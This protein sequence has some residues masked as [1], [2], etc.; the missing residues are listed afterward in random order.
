LPA[1]DL[2]NTLCATGDYHINNK[3]SLGDFLAYMDSIRMANDSAPLTWF[4][5][6]DYIYQPLDHDPLVSFSSFPSSSTNTN[7]T[8]PCSISFCRNSRKRIENGCVNSCMAKTVT[9]LANLFPTPSL[10]EATNNDD[11]YSLFQSIARHF[12]LGPVNAG[13]SM[14][15]YNDHT[16]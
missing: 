2:L 12:Y 16:W 9:S 1:I 3:I 13:R 14:Q 15:F 10:L 7:G 4:D 6:P 8:T 11:S 5:A